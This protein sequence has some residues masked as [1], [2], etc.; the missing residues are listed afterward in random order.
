MRERESSNAD[1]KFKVA[2]ERG[3]SGG[4]STCE[5]AAK[6]SADAAERREAAAEKAARKAEKR[7]REAEVREPF[8]AIE[9]DA[10]F[11]CQLNAT[12]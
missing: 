9:L 8:E 11:C 1:P 10:P 2:T 12:G 6:H 3:Q 5:A 4:L 7:V